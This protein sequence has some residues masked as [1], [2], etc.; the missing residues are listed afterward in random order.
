MNFKRISKKEFHHSGDGKTCW[1]QRK[2]LKLFLEII[3]I[4]LIVTGG[5]KV[6]ESRKNSPY[7]QSDEPAWIFAGY[8]FNLYFLRF[9]LF[10]QDWSD[11]EALDQPPLAKYIVGGSVYL[12]GYTIDSLRVKRLW[13]NLPVDKLPVFFDSIKHEIP[14]PAIVIPFARS[15]IFL[16]AL[17]SLILI[18]I[19]VRTLYG[20]LAAFISTS[21]IISSPIHNY[22]SIRI[23]ADPILLFF[24][25]LFVLLCAL[26][27]KSQKNIYI[28]LASIASSF[29]FLTKLNGI[30]LVPL[31][32]II[33]L[34][35]NK[36]SFSKIDFKSGVIAL[37]AFLLISAFLNPVFL[38]SGIKAL[39]EMA[40][41]RRSAFVVFQETYPNHA[42]LSVVDRLENATRIIF[43]R[44][45]LFYPL[46]KIPVELF[47]FVIGIYYVLSKRD[48]FLVSVFVFLVIIPISI[49]PFNMPR[50]LYWIFPFIYVVAG[51]SSNLFKE[52]VSKRNLKLLKIMIS[53]LSKWH[54]FGSKE[55]QKE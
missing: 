42:L 43:F 11:Y 20:V 3:F 33:V 37:T 17:S 34:I 10:H 48:L 30:L 53:P 44:S 40:E 31:L 26:Y 14:N 21:L 39:W 45:S 1:L 46:I 12:K 8:Y 52:M 41:V 29:A 15:V 27:W 54:N 2:Y 35:K 23:L 22:Y 6:L 18:Y 16:F 32:I 7:L 24:L 51:F 25:S 5:F 50:Y 4:L 49:L 38:N 47:L 9:D 55:N 28:V 13:N 36:F 19:S